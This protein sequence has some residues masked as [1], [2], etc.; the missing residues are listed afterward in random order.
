MQL[1]KARI[2]KIWTLQL[3][4]I[5][6]S[7]QLRVPGVMTCSKQTHLTS[8]QHFS[9]FFRLQGMQLYVRRKVR[10]AVSIRP[11]SSSNENQLVELISPREGPVADNTDFARQIRLGHCLASRLRSFFG[12]NAHCVQ[13]LYPQRSCTQQCQAYTWATIHHT[14]S[15]AQRNISW[16]NELQQTESGHSEKL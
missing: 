11:I 12:V 6:L 16:K 14:K 1:N 15:T 10:D 2:Y 7:Q 8:S 5:L 3:S 13:S 4:R 9:H